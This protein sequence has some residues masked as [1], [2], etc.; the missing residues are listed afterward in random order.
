MIPVNKLLQAVI[1]VDGSDLHLAVGMPPTIRH[2][3]RLRP[4]DL[5]VVTPDDTAA[6][7]KAIAPDRCQVELNEVGTTDFG[8]SFADAARFRVSI[9]NQKQVLGLALRLIPSEMLSFEQIGLPPTIK[10]LLLKPHG[11]VLVSGPTGCGKTTTLATMID[12]LNTETYKHIVTLEDPIEYYHDHKNSII[13]QREIGVDCPSFEEGLRR[14]LRQDP[15]VI[16]VG[17]MRDL[18][19]ME[20][21]IRAAETGHLVFATLHTTGAAKTIDRIIDAFPPDQQEQIRTQL[22]TSL[23]AAISQLLLPRAGGKGRIAAFE[24]MLMKDSIANLIR[25]KE[26]HKLASDIQTGRGEGM[27]LL[28]DHLYELYMGGKITFADMMRSSS[29]PQELEKK[30]KALAAAKKK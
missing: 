8:F 2:D 4:L 7:M 9:F 6:V 12:F 22:S 23:A 19:T 20:A 13:T 21:A 16:L 10:N 3:G 15:D 24:I 25:K 27:I 11:L 1:D 30:I 28:D 18:E 26:T 14:V 5:P 29:K 17:E